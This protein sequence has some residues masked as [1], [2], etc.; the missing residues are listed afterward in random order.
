M[1]YYVRF[2]HLLERHDVK[3]VFIAN[4]YSPECLALAA[5]AHRSGRKVLFTNHANAT[6][7]E[8]YL[9]PLYSDLAAVT[10]QAV[11]DTYQKNSSREIGAV[12]V[13]QVSAQR[14]MR[15]QVEPKEPVTVGIFLTALTSMTRLSA[16]IGQLESDP[17]VGRIVI[18]PHPVMVVNE[19]LSDI[20]VEGGRVENAGGMPLYDNIELC[21]VAICGNS[22]VTIELLRGGVPVFYDA[23][24]DG[25]SYD[26][27]GYVKH[28][29]VLPMPSVLDRPALQALDRFYGSPSW[30]NTM[31]YFDAGYQREEAEMFRRLND[32]LHRTVHSSASV[33]V[34]ARPRRPAADAPY[35]AGAS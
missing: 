5:A 29:L 2:R 4:H 33:D 24:L 28:G 1:T 3:A 26:Y 9:P 15:S 8:G 27:N 34:R 6:W 30:V 35:P 20:C 11:L 13:P 10:S 25:L 7:H 12:F 17:K 32:A 23:D 22:T 14:S 18:R 19:D 21:D 16:L 31:R